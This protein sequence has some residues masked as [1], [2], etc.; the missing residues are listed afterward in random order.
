MRIV[1]INGFTNRGVWEFPASLIHPC[2]LDSP[3]P[4][5]AFLRF[6][7]HLCISTSG[8]HIFGYH[9]ADVRTVH[10]ELIYNCDNGE[11]W[12]VEGIDKSLRNGYFSERKFPIAWKINSAAH[13]SAQ[14][15]TRVMHNVF[16][17]QWRRCILL[18]GVTWIW[19]M[20][21]FGTCLPLGSLICLMWGMCVLIAV[22][23]PFRIIWSKRHTP[24]LSLYWPMTFRRWLVCVGNVLKLYPPPCR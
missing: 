9:E 7:R 11:R 10:F 20:Q 5:P 4:A 23:L 19:R 21:K 8:L 22:T 2:I 18:W 17:N 14:R 6:G 13:I 15:K 1:L 3:S 12:R 24:P 16:C